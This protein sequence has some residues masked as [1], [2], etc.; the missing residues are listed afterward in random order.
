M[1]FIFLK[2]YQ[3]L[4]KL[5]IISFC[6]KEFKNAIG[7]K[8]KSPWITDDDGEPVSDSQFIIEH[9]M[10][11]HNIQM[12]KLTPEESAVARSLRALVE[13]NLVRNMLCLSCQLSL[14]LRD[15]SQYHTSS[16]RRS[17]GSRN[18]A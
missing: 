6:S 15:E 16:D 2:L 9:L 14:L 8:G 13:D 1:H 10:K 3:Q 12:L 4:V 11:K 7:P 5:L 18:D 17:S